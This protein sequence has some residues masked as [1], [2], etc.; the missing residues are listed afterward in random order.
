MTTYARIQND[1]AIEVFV[2]HEGFTLGECFHPEIAALFSVVPDGTEAGATLANG[3]WTNPPAT[4]APEPAATAYPLL[5][6][7]QFYLSFTPTERM[8][9]K[10]LAA[11]GGVLAN[12]P[13]FGNSTAIPQD[14]EI[15]EFW[16]TFELAQSLNDPVN[17]NLVSVQEGLTYLSAPTAPTPAVITAA[18]IPQILVGIAQ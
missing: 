4:S 9:I 7:M 14:P 3:T 2:P 13:L 18:R 8:K 6:P 15:A 17:P 1:T 10:A 11:T 5:T 16:A 12:S